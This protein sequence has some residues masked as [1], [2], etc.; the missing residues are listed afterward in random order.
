LLLFG[1]ASWRALFGVVLG[2][3]IGAYLGAVAGLAYHVV[4]PRTRHLGRWG[5]YLTGIAFASGFF[6]AFMLPAAISGAELGRDPMSWVAAG[7]VAVIFGLVVGHFGLR[8]L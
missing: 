2:V 1:E 3:L 6:L 7:I 5:D 8:D 4:R